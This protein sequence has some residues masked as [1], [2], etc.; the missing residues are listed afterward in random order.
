MMKSGRSSD[1]PNPR[2]EGMSGHEDAA[3]DLK[4]G[5][6][7][8]AESLAREVLELAERAGKLVATAESCTGGLL[9]TL[10]TDVPGV[11]HRFECGFV[12]YSDASKVRLLGI[13]GELIE[14]HG[15]VSKAVA[16]E[17]ARGSLT[18]SSADIALSVTGFAGPAG[19]DDEEG[20]VHMAVATSSGILE[21]QEYHF[22]TLGRDGV[23]DRALIEGLIMLRKAMD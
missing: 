7:P 4:C 10:L 5:A 14:H 22:G 23:R 1:Q 3:S 16:I 12:V 17:M 19:P 15:A 8:S 21:H 20:L 18:R 9:A 13:C 6:T 11:S 2:T